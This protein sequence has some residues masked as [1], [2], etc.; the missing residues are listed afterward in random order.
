M[1]ETAGRSTKRKQNSEYRGPKDLGRAESLY[2]SAITKPDVEY[3]VQLLFWALAANPEHEG[4][5][6]AVLDKGPEI[7]GR[8]KLAARVGE[9]LSG[10]PADEFVRQLAAF[11][12]FPSA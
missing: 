9:A 7:A 3:C 8:K 2:Q 1:S 10:S 6:K 11:V 4:S 5:F 12:A